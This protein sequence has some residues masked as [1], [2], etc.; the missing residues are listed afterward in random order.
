MRVRDYAEEISGF[1]WVQLS[2]AGTVAGEYRGGKATGPWMQDFLDTGPEDAGDEY[3][4]ELHWYEDSKIRFH[5]SHFLIMDPRRRSCFKE[6]PH[7]C[8]SVDA[9]GAAPGMREEL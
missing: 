7:A 9:A 3:A 5:F 8:A 4:C 6:P 1:G 2:P